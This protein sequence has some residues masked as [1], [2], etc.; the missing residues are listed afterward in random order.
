M[1]NNKEMAARRKQAAMCVSPPN[2]YK[3]FYV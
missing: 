3:E 2:S 1:C